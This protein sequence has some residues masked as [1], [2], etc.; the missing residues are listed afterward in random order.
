MSVSVDKKGKEMMMKGKMVEVVME[1]SRAPRKR[2][3][4][5]RR[6]RRRRG[7][8]SKMLAQRKRRCVKV[9]AKARRVRRRERKTE[10]EKTEEAKQEAALE[11]AV[12]GKKED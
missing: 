6:R 1:V 3:R 12:L 5:R 9:G 10:A 8:T 7:M 4:G 2:G 11:G